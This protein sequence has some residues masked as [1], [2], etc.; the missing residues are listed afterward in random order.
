MDN[1]FHIAG[2]A[3]V[4]LLG[5]AA[6]CGVKYKNIQS[7]TKSFMGPEDKLNSELSSDLGFLN[8]YHLRSD[9]EK[10]RFDRIADKYSSGKIDESFNSIPEGA[11]KNELRAKRA[12]I[13]NLLKNVV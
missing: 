5:L 13:E 10:D 9:E 1:H 4:G 8:N 3:I 6:Y 2:G 7:K 11:R 12:R